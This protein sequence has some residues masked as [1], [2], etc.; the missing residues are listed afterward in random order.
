[1]LESLDASRA[2]NVQAVF[3]FLEDVFVGNWSWV[4]LLEVV[5]LVVLQLT[6]TCSITEL[7]EK[8]EITVFCQPFLADEISWSSRVTI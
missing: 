4:P 6:L 8:D 3:V 1:M 5:F 2:K 7:I